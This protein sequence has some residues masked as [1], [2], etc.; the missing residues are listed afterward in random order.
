MLLYG[1]THT[2]ERPL[3][4]G[5]A[6]M[7]RLGCVLRVDR[8]ARLDDGDGTNHRHGRRK[9]KPGMAFARGK[10]SF[11][12]RRND[13]QQRPMR[14]A[15]SQGTTTRRTTRHSWATSGKYARR[16]APL[17]HLHWTR[18][19]LTPA[20]SAPGLGSP[21]GGCV[22][23]CVTYLEGPWS[24]TESTLAHTSR[25]VFRPHLPSIDWKSARKVHA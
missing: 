17:P 21:L 7:F 6:V 8:S 3:R 18:T 22:R 4:F 23:D 2:C 20:T 19:G 1:H 10:G 12:M 25:Y 15:G 24:S 14:S 13:V 11:L 9:A 16:C 5:M